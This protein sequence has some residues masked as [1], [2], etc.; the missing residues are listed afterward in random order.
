MKERTLALIQRKVEGETITAPAAPAE[1][2][3]G[4]VV[5]STEVLKASLAR[6]GKAQAAAG[7]DVAAERKPPKRASGEAA[8]AKKAANGK[9]AKR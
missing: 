3:E 6:S 9:R 4:R 7:A 8:P 5:D 2:G 1:P